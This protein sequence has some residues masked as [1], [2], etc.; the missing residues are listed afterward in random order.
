MDGWWSDV[1]REI[2]ACLREQGRASPAVIAHHLGMSEAAAT[3]LLAAMASEGKLR[4]DA[5]TFPE[6]PRPPEHGARAG[7]RPGEVR[8]V[9][10]ARD[11][12]RRQADPARR[13]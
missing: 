7:S 8:H 10:A 1:E 6:A 3:S 5:V 9:R 2:L 11:T 4:I 12:A 13:S